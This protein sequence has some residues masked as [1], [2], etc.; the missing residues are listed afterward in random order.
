MARILKTPDQNIHVELDV[1]VTHFPVG[2]G[3]QRLWN[4][5]FS[6]SWF[7]GPGFD[8]VPTATI[9]ESF[10]LNGIWIYAK[11]RKVDVRWGVFREPIPS[12]SSSALED[13]VE[14]D[15]LDVQEWIDIVSAWKIAFL[16]FIVEFLRQGASAV[17]ARGLILR[18]IRRKWAEGETEYFS[19]LEFSFDPR[20]QIRVWIR[21]DFVDWSQTMTDL[22]D[23][24]T[25]SLPELLERLELPN[26]AV[27]TQLL[28]APDSNDGQGP[29]VRC[30]DETGGAS[31]LRAESHT[32]PGGE[33]SRKNRFAGDEDDRSIEGR[34]GA[35]KQAG[36]VKNLL[37][38]FMTFSLGRSPG[39]PH[40]YHRHE[41]E[42]TNGHRHIRGIVFAV[43]VPYSLQSRQQRDVD[44]VGEPV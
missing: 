30:V 7:E 42:L 2:E 26:I 28:K 17:V 33:I 43:A 34:Q 18:R 8:N 4:H 20:M 10:L 41:V 1:D 15:K 37:A 3:K 12:P 21:A 14:A 16:Y 23:R 5:Y 22:G 19:E 27:L 32:H 11:M 29:E 9:W 40:I 44:G 6:T 35:T 31:Q 24:D 36:L 38:S 39:A 25:F 13:L